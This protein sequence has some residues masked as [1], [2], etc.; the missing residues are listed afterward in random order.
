MELRFREDVVD[1]TAVTAGLTPGGSASAS[2]AFSRLATSGWDRGRLKL[3]GPAM[4]ML[5]W[6]CLE[7]EGVSGSS[8]SPTFPVG[9]ARCFPTRRS[10][11]MAGWDSVSRGLLLSPQRCSGVSVRLRGFHRDPCS[12]TEP[13]RG[14]A[15]HRELIS[16]HINMGL[17]SM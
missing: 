6:I 11:A 5:I 12:S 13:E 15:R 16:I 4:V 14:Q 10:F 9:L 3:Y 8:V 17:V 1:I 7:A 2:K